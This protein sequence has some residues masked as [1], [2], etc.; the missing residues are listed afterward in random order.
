MLHIYIILLSKNLW[1][2]LNRSVNTQKF[3]MLLCRQ[4]IES[5]FLTCIVDPCLRQVYFHNEILQRV[6]ITTASGSSWLHFTTSPSGETYEDQFSGF[7]KWLSWR[8]FFLADDF[9][10]FWSFHINV[11]QK[12]C[13]QKRQIYFSV[14]LANSWNDYKLSLRISSHSMKGEF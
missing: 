5:L 3:T 14:F 9:F 7:W 6:T 10:L 4:S 11:K 8:L 13:S 12:I 1:F 2:C